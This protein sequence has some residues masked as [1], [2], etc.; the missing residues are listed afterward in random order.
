MAPQRQQELS[1]A[2]TTS[3]LYASMF[4]LT[5]ISYRVR[6]AVSSCSQ[7]AGGGAGQPRCYA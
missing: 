4:C 5:C 7:P 6:N 3:L 1:A 2:R